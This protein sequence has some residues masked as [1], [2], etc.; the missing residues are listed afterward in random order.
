MQTAVQE[1]KDN[2][3]DA[4]MIHTKLTDEVEKPDPQL[5]EKSKVLLIRHA[6]TPFNVEF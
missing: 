4:H 5:L 6:T 3:G 2:A 1:A